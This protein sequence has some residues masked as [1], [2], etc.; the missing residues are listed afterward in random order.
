M[1]S[2][3]DVN[4]AVLLDRDA[5][6]LRERDSVLMVFDRLHKKVP[7]K[8]AVHSWMAPFLKLPRTD[9]EQLS[10]VLG[11]IVYDRRGVN[12][13]LAVLQLILCW[14]LISGSLATLRRQPWGLT[15]WSFAC[16]SSVFF[17]LLSMLVTF[18][19]SRTLMS[20]LGQPTAAALAHATGNSAELELAGLWQL[21]RFY[22][23][24]RATMEGLWVLILGLCALYLQRYQHS[25]EP[26]R[27]SR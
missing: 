21:T 24:L 23:V 9:A 5:F 7:E 22:V 25:L 16:W 11:D 18:V 3:T 14:L 20:R 19:H 6:V 10:L 13:P 2:L 26:E 15:T 17:A 1:S 27:A 8:E 4:S 12:V